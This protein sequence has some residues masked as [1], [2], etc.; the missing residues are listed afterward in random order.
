[1]LVPVRDLVVR[2]V[3]VSDLEVSVTTSVAVSPVSTLV[4]VS[5]ALKVPTA[6]AVPVFWFL[7]FQCQ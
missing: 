3:T 2:L 5:L 7:P 1:M 6:T 4:T